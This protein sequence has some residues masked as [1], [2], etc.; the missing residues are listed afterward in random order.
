LIEGSQHLTIDDRMVRKL[1]AGLVVKCELGS[2]GW[3]YG[4]YWK[5][6]SE[7]LGTLRSGETFDQI[8]D[9]WLLKKE[10]AL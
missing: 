2:C 9:F 8:S 4:S 7:T 10:F 5:S 3:D 1:T 6:Y